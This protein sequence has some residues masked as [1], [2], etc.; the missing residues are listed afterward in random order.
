MKTLFIIA[1]AGL[2]FGERNDDVLLVFD[3]LSYAQCH[4]QGESISNAIQRA[5]FRKI[6]YVCE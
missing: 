2:S 3:Q 6:T 5:S 1:I 4:E